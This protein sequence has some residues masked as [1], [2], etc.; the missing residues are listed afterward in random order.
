MAELLI[1]IGVLALGLLQLQQRQRTRALALRVHHAA[2]R[3]LEQQ[4]EREQNHRLARAQRLS[5]SVVEGTT[6]LV[7]SVHQN[8]AAIPFGLLETVPLVGTV[9]RGVRVVHDGTADTVYDAIRAA[10]KLAGHTLR[11]VLPGKQKS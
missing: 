1:F 2:I 7:Q 3:Q 4:L 6:D 11:Q 5:E 9:A 10:N 8:I